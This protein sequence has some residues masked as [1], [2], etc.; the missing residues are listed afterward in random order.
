MLCLGTYLAHIPIHPQY[1]CPVAMVGGLIFLVCQR[2]HDRLRP[3]HVPNEALPSSSIAANICLE[4]HRSNLL[5]L[6]LHDL[7]QFT[8]LWQLHVR[9]DIRLL[10]E[11]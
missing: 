7:V 11:T 4:T 9:G 6:P 5:R 10:P 1:I 3:R 8:V 2:P